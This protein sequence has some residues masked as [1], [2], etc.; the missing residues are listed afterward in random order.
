MAGTAFLSAILLWLTV[1]MGL[2]N[3]L[4]KKLQKD[5]REKM[6]DTDQLF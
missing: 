2:G 5:K 4:L 6:A 1:P 3:N